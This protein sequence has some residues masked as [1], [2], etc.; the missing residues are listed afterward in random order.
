MFLSGPIIVLRGFRDV[1]GSSGGVLNGGLRAKQCNSFKWGCICWSVDRSSPIRVLLSGICLTNNVFGLFPRR[2]SE[3][4]P[5]DIWNIPNI[6]ARRGSLGLARQ[7]GWQARTSAGSLEKPLS[8]SCWGGEVEGWGG[9]GG[10]WFVSGVRLRCFPGHP[11]DELFRVRP[12]WER[13][14]TQWGSKMHPVWLG[15]SLGIPLD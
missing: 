15:E 12:I 5:I 9:S 2:T 4:Y 13:T 10:S 11:P 1:L 6:L 8:L 3:T 14:R 7:S